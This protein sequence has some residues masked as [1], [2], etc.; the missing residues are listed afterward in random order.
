MTPAEY[1]LALHQGTAFDWAMTWRD[2]NGDVIDLSGSE[3]L[4][5]IRRRTPSRDPVG[6]RSTSSATITLSDSTPNIVVHFTSDFLRDLPSDNV[7]Q[8]WDYGLKLIQSG[9]TQTLLQGPL[10]LDPATARSQS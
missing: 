4:F 1:T 9:V 3:A 8:M 6:E 5:Q 2:D 10:R 7:P